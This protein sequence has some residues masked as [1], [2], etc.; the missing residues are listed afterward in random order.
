MLLRTSLA[1]LSALALGACATSKPVPSPS[2]QAQAVLEAPSSPTPPAPDRRALIQSIV[3]SNVRLEFRDGEALKR[4]ASGVV[5]GTE[6]TTTGSVSYIMTN[7]H[8]LD[9]GGFENPRLIVAVERDGIEQT[10]LGEV[11]AVGSVPDMDLALLRVRGVALESVQLAE[12]EDLSLGEEVVVAASPFGR[13]L[14]L[15]SGM[16]SRID[17]RDGVAHMVKTDAPVGYGSSGGGI[18]SLTS[19]RLLG[20][21]EGYRT[22]KM[23]FNVQAE[24]YSFE[25]PMPGETFAAPVTKVRSFLRSHGLSRLIPGDAASVDGTTQTA[26]VDG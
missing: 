19:G 15:A 4:T 13:S 24:R 23:G 17:R 11:L 6:V 14:S 5:V 8:A 10:Y 16:V 1:C 21:V 9:D 22:A 26:R 12:E 25:V 20:V 7:A 18:Y 3:A 2:E